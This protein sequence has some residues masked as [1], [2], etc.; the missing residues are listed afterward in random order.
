[1]IY[2]RPDL[3][4]LLPLAAL[5][6]TLAVLWQWRRSRRLAAAFGGNQAARRLTGRSLRRFPTARLGCTVLAAL[7]LTLAASGARQDTAE[8][9]PPA[10]PV[11]LVVALDVSHSM[12]AADVD[13]SR[14]EVARASVDRVVA[15]RVAD[16]IALS[17]F[18]GWPY[19]LVPITDDVAVVEY[20]VPWLQPQLLQQRD[21][22]TALADVLD[23]AVER[24]AAR[25]RDGSIPVLLVLSDGEAHGAGADVLAA[26]NR[27]AEEGLRI[28]TAG[29]GTPEGAPLFVSGSGGAPL[30]EGSG[31]QVVAGYDADLL[32]DMARIGGGAFHALSA[33]EDVDGLVAELRRLGGE[34]ASTE[35]APFD[36]T[37]L[38]LII[39]LA[40]LATDAILDS[41]VLLGGRS[42]ATVKGRS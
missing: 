34:V 26:A 9:P 1:M 31:G 6:M 4:V 24:W 32:R 10:T 36:P 11:D 27:A 38:L 18:A 5:V 15:S 20:F 42:R 33:P 30:L 29:V 7:A 13:P 8:P 41:G 3:L 21:Q 35:E 39:A 19:G 14:F 37:M 40:L 25:S 16:R 17:L 2:D 23:H 22:G 12:S 28:W